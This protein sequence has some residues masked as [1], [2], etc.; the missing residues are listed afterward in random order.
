MLYFKRAEN[1][2]LNFINAQEK[3]EK[4]KKKFSLFVRDESPQIQLQVMSVHLDLLQ[5]VFAERTQSHAFEKS[6]WNK[7]N[8]D[9]RK[10][11]VRDASIFFIAKNYQRGGGEEREREK[12]ICININ[13]RFYV[14][15]V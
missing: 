12:Y 1:N 2:C 8:S 3:V 4:K 9:R 15:I 14:T 7:R 11:N 10:R 5:T 6:L 13:L